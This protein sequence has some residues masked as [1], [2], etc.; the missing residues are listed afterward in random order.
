[1]E[2]PSVTI[3]HTYRYGT[4]FWRVEHAGAVYTLPAENLA[5]WGLLGALPGLL[6]AKGGAA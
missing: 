6:A 3:S 5:L 4:R 1:M 2:N